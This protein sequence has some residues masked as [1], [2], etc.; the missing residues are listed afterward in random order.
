MLF[1]QQLKLNAFSARTVSKCVTT[2][3]FLLLWE[4]ALQNTE[5]VFS[6]HVQYY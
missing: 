6:F 1:P 5:T 2:A 3:V 4:N